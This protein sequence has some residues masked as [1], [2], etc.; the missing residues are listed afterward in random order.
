MA[1]Q[2]NN[3]YP[4]FNFLVDLGDGVS[5]TVTAG[6]SEVSGLSFSTEIVEY[7]NG[8]DRHNGITKLAGLTR[9]DNVVLRRGLIGALGLYQWLRQIADGDAAARR[10][11]TITLLAEDQSPVMTWKLL[12]AQIVRH[13]SGPFNAV[14]TAVAIEAIEIAFERLE[15]E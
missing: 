10:T 12:R 9:C 1:V 5:E 8:N 2:R 15:I 7:R 3:P 6:F 14:S 11:V 4:G 13:V